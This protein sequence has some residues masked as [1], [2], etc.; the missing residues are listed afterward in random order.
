MV[1]LLAVTLVIGPAVAGSADD[2]N[3]AY[4][5][6]SNIGLILQI[7][8]LCGGDVAPEIAIAS[9]MARKLDAS[10]FSAGVIIAKTQISKEVAAKNSVQFCALA[11]ALYGPN[12]R[13]M[14]GAWIPPK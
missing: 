12:G 3:P 14:K 1:A 6:G 13:D 9:E 11:L 8:E 2:S 4:R 7:K 5:A 10:A